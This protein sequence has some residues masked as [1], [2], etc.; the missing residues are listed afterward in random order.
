MRQVL[1]IELHCKIAS[2]QDVFLSP[3]AVQCQIVAVTLLQNITIYTI[4][5]KFLG[6]GSVFDTKRAALEVK[7]NKSSI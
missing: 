3:T 4:H 1:T 2:R 5:G 7:I 6:T